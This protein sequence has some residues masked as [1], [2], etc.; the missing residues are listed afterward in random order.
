MPVSLSDFRSLRDFVL[1]EKEFTQFAHSEDS[2][3]SFDAMQAVS[4]WSMV[5]KAM[6]ELFVFLL[7]GNSHRVSASFMA[8]DCFRTKCN[9]VAAAATSAL[10]ETRLGTL[11]KLLAVALKAKR[12]RDRLENWTWGYSD[13]FPNALLLIEPSVDA[14]DA[15]SSRNV[16]VYQD[17]DLRNIMC[18]HTRIAESLNLYQKITLIEGDPTEASEWLMEWLEN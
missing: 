11:K 13:T 6:L 7:R 12:R 5:E 16:F 9:I 14:L 1:Q 2:P 3:L 8:V 15:A 4:S 18:E 17:Y 10:S